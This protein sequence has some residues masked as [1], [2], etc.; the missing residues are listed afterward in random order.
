MTDYP[1]VVRNGV[2]LFYRGFMLAFL[3]TAVLITWA[4]ASG[5]TVEPDRWWPYIMALFLA[6]GAWGLAW[7]LNLEAGVIRITQPKSI[8]IKRGK[9]FRREDHWTDR[10]RFWIEDGKDSDGDLYFKLKMDAPGGDLTIKEGHSRPAL[11]KLLA[12]ID[13]AVKG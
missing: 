3:G 13:V 2:P 7:T 4:A 12:E 8:H 9:A 5:S 10:A 11:E 6:V 1:L